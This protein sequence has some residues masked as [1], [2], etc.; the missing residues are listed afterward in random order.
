MAGYMSTNEDGT[1]SFNL[2]GE[3]PDLREPEVEDD[4]LVTLFATKERWENYSDPYT[5]EFDCNIRAWIEANMETDKW[6]IKN[7]YWRRYTFGMVW[8]EIYGRPYDSKTDSKRAYRFSKILA[9]YSSKIAKSGSVRGK[10]RSKSIYTFSP[11]RFKK[12]R[13][14]SLKL[15]LELL[16][17]EGKVPTWRNLK[18]PKD[19]LTAGHARNPRT[20]ANMRRRREE[21]RRI[22]NERYKDRNH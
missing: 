21:G 3:P 12:V 13:P 14:Y 22:Y 16:E 19:N 8:E 17:K 15:Q 4:K 11:K 1:W 5:Y 10:Q 2:D 20:E 7:P 18:L 6:K 9:H